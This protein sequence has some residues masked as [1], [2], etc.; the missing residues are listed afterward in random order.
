M[1]SLLLMFISLIPLSLLAQDGPCNELSSP[2]WANGINSKVEGELPR[3]RQV[4]SSFLE[5]K[6]SISPKNGFI[7]LQIHVSSEGEICDIISFEIDQNYDPTT[8][9][10]GTLS[11]DL[12]KEIRHFTWIRKKPFK[13]YN[14]IRFKIENGKI[15]EIF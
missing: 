10:E 6:K 12:I 9:N 11:E 4:Y 14:L 5:S 13:T 8:F 1:K 3:I 15:I 2:Y 7:T